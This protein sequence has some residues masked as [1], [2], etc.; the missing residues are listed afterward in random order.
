MLGGL[1]RKGALPTRRT[2]LQWL[3][4]FL[5]D[6]EGPRFR[7]QPGRVQDDPK[8]CRCMAATFL[9][10]LSPIQD[11]MGDGPGL[12]KKCTT[13]VLQAEWLPAARYRDDKW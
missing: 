3:S 12:H 8:E 10:A 4:R 11:A 7:A 9:V 6:P 1:Q 5:G 2:P 13:S